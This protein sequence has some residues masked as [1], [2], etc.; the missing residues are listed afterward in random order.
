M[1]ELERRG[2]GAKDMGRDFEDIWR[3]FWLKD[4]GIGTVGR[5]GSHQ[6]N[7]EQEDT[8]LRGL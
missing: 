3:Y 7:G 4:K 1:G 6:G 8:G 5:V 2:S